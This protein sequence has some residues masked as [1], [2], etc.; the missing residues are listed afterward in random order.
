[1]PEHFIAIEQRLTEMDAMVAYLQI[2]GRLTN[3]AHAPLAQAGTAQ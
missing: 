2:L 1:V 3:A